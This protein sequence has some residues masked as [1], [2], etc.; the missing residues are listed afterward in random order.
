MTATLWIARDEAGIDPETRLL[1]LTLLQRAVA[2]GQRAG[3]GRV[4]VE[5][6]TGREGQAPPLRHDGG[7]ERVVVLSMGVIPEKKWLRELRQMP[8]E[9]GVVE[10][11]PGCA[12]VVETKNPGEIERALLSRGKEAAT[13]TLARTS[14]GAPGHLSSEDRFVVK[15]PADLPRAEKWL[16]SGLIKDSEGFMSRHVERRIS[17]AISRRLASTNVTPNQMTIVSVAIGI[18]GAALFLSP[19]PW[20]PFVGSLLVLAHSILD[21]CD[22]ELARLKFRESRF[23]GVLDFWGDNVVHCALF[24]AISI[25]WAREAGRA[26]PLAFG[27]AAVL[28][29]ILSAGFVF[30]KT[31]MGAREGPLFQ[32]VVQAPDTAF[33]KVADAL[34]RRDFLYLAVI[35]SA[36]RWQRYFL[37]LAAAGSLVYFVVLVALSSGGRRKAAPGGPVRVD[38]LERNLS[39]D[40]A[41]PRAPKETS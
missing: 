12:A 9:E 13:E 11:D 39:G 17:L 25:A 30:R 14:A 41:V 4:F 18:L 26:W 35:L 16:L 1:G 23:G 27:A 2:V 22:G 10:V 38:N 20:V 31:M 19:N 7:L 6:T 21:G 8:V 3:F 33:A 28:G 24:A 15:A 34:A 29:T 5:S 32:S 40:L 36:F 37:A